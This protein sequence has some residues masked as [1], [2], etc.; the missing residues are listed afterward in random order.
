MLKSKIFLS[1]SEFSPE[2]SPSYHDWVIGSSLLF[3]KMCGLIW[4]NGLL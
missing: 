4:L 1:W 3:H 2:L